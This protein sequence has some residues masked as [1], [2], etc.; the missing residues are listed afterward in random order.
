MRRVTDV[1]PIHR[2]GA[3]SSVRN[4]ETGPSPEEPDQSLGSLRIVVSS[5]HFEWLTTQCSFLGITK[6][7]LVADALE[8]WICRN[9]TMKLP[10]D[11]SATEA[12]EQIHLPSS[13]RVLVAPRRRLTPR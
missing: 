13:R 11:Q 6:Q 9:E 8:E 4:K 12:F 2:S 1:R 7:Q 3:I 10:V 5:L